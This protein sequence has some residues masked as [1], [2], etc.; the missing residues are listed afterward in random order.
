M[1]YS[2]FDEQNHVNW[3][4]EVIAKLVDIIFFNDLEFSFFKN[5]YSFYIHFF[6]EL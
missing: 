3:G 5:I 4:V 6:T 1:N 2:G